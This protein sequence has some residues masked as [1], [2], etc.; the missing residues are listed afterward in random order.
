MTQAQSIV[1]AVSVTRAPR[2]PVPKEAALSEPPMPNFRQMR[3][4]EAWWVESV[5]VLL[6]VV[7]VMVGIVIGCLA[8]LYMRVFDLIAFARKVCAASLDSEMP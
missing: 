3:D 4:R 8:A 1:E 2:T 5:G 6:G 7:V